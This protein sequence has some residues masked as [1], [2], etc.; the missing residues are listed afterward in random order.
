[1]PI[2]NNDAVYVG[3]YQGNISALGLSSGE[4]LWEHQLSTYSGLAVDA[5]NVYVTDS[6][7]VLWAFNKVTGR[8]NW[9]QAALQSYMLTGPVT[10]KNY[11]IL[12]DNLGNVQVFLRTDGQSVGRSKLS[13]K[14]FYV[15]PMTD[16]KAVYMFDSHGKLIALKVE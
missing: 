11:I 4:R 6:D 8:V 5:N 10:Y 7:G 2:V 15:A 13:S 16:G 14:A 1:M 12:G 9:K 3:T